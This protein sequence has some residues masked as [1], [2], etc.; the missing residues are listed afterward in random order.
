[1]HAATGAWSRRCRNSLAGQTWQQ[2]R[3]RDIV[4][5]KNKTAT[6]LGAQ[7]L[8]KVADMGT[9]VVDARAH[10]AAADAAAAPE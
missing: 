5:L 9:A 2:R 1:M 7:R 8:K 10:C 6:I 4:T 3:R